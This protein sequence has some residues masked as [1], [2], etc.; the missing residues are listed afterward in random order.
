[1]AYDTSGFAFDGPYGGL[2]VGAENDFSS[3]YF[4]LG[5]AVG[6]LFP[7]GSGLVGNVEGSAAYYMGASNGYEFEL[8]SRLGTTVGDFLLF[9]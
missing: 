6:M 8:T 1:M 2:I 4:D 7:L 5:G 3:L 9:G